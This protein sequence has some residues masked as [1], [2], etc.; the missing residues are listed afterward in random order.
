[1]DMLLAQ[2]IASLS[3]PVAVFTT[4]LLPVI[5][6]IGIG[7]IIHSVFTPQE[8]ATNAAVGYAKFSV[9]TE[10]Y[11]VIA[12]LTLVG[13]WDI[14]QNSRDVIQRE[15]NALYML[16]LSAEAYGKPVQEELRV[17]MRFSIR[18]YASEVVGEEWPVMQGRGRT[19]NSENAFQLLAETFLTAEPLTDAQ[20]AIAPNIPQW[21][22]NI[23]E[24]RITRLSMMSRTISSIVW[25]LLLASS[26]AI[27]AFQWFFAGARSGIHFAMGIVI[28]MII[29]GVLLTCLKL[30][31]PFN[32][33][34]PLLSSRPFLA[35][36]EIR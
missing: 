19:E 28:S 17:A 15:T 4:V 27:L 23:S 31:F 8:L 29:G 34:Y 18:N 7:G 36:M 12:A 20:R 22:S 6:A 33:D 11:A 10:I 13:S 16:A 9:L 24:T 3:L 2:S 5:L 14:Y 26:A 32:G 25:T 35:I 30:A 21:I 1:M